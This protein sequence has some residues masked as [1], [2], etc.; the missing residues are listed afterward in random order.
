MK[1][2]VPYA[3]VL[4]T[5]LLAGCGSKSDANVKESSDATNAY[6]AKKGQAQCERGS[7]PIGV[8]LAERSRETR[9]SLYPHPQ[10][11]ERSRRS[12]PAGGNQGAFPAL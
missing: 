6:L 2:S 12:H 11:A 1:I 8:L 5:L 7:R 3:M 4:G 10:R 9:E